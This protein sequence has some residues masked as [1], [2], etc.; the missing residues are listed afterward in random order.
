M[1]KD[2]IKWMMG[3]AC[4]LAFVSCSQTEEG[5]QLRNEN[6]I[7]FSARIASPRSGDRS[8]H[9]LPDTR[10]EPFHASGTCRFRGPD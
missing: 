6:G 9:R 5:M 7:R 2:I 1:K 10:M 3:Y 4:F 8:R